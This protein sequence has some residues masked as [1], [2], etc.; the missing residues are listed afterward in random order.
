VSDVDGV[1]SIA[2]S[3][4]A[5]FAVKADGTV[6]AWG[7]NGAGQLGDGTTTS[8]ATPAP[9]R[10]LSGVTAIAA[11]DDA[12]F[13]N[14]SVLALKSDGTVWAWGDN[15]HGQLG[16]GTTMNRSVPVQ[17]RDLDGVIALATNNGHSL[18]LKADGTVWAWGDNTYGV[19]GDGT[20]VERHTPVRVQ[21]L[22]R[23][24]AIATGFYRSLAL[25]PST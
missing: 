8:R 21:G 18:A 13:C 10:G 1:V 12:C 22:G 24:T 2:A 16:D 17:V 7:F 3:Y 5:S 4:Y 20:I 9:V 25:T 19:L 14:N 15:S 11:D 6:W 23:V